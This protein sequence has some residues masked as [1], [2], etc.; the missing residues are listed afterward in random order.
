MHHE[1]I[2]AGFGGQGILSAG[3]LLAYA[4][5]LDGKEVSWLP[6]YG[7]E[8]RGGTAN[9]MVVISDD[10]VASPVIY[11]CTCLLVMNN[12]SMLKFESFVTPGGVIV[13]DSTIVSTLPTRV[14]VEAFGVPSSRLAS[15]ENVMAYSNVYLLGK[16]IAKTNCVTVE[17]FEEALYGILPKR[18]HGMIPEEMKVLSVGMNYPA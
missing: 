17:N 8:M 16:L 18:H 11:S 10:P 1:I 6:S 13:Y 2:V 14:D 15:D 4:G 5:M 7:P 9:S 12:P 3:R